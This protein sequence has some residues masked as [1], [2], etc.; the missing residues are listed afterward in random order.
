MP[1]TR[2]NCAGEEP[3]YLFAV[4]LKIP[5]RQ[6]WRP[7]ES[8]VI[9]VHLD[10]GIRAGRLKCYWIN[11]WQARMQLLRWIREGCWIC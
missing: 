5:Y 9:V 3:R 2:R 10:T 6:L 7:R 11:F 4:R 8:A 1:L